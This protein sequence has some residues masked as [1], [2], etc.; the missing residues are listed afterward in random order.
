M[1]AWVRLPDVADS[2]NVRWADETSTASVDSRT[3]TFAR[4]DFYTDS[5]MVASEHAAVDLRDGARV[6]NQ[7]RHCSVF[8]RRDNA[9]IALLPRKKA[10]RHQMEIRKGDELLVGNCVFAVG[11]EVPESADPMQSGG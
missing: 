10:G 7:A 3:G 9:V 6:E 5:I 2:R 4:K 8:V 11:G 1:A